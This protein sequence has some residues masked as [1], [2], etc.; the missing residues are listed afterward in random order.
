MTTTP[1]HPLGFLSR[2]S[3]SIYV[4]KPDSAVAPKAAGTHPRLILLATW[5][6]A[7]DVHIAKY[8]SPY[9]AAYPSSPI[10]VVRTELSDFMIPGR[11]AARSREFAGV[12]PIL[13]E[14]FPQLG[15]GGVVPAPQDDTDASSI[16]S[17]S[18]SDIADSDVSGVLVKSS[19]PRPE[20]LIHVWSNGGSTAL[21]HIRA[22]LKKAGVQLPRYSFVM[23]STPGQFHYRSTFTAF[24]LSF[25]PWLRRLLSPFLH[26][27]VCWFWLRQN[28][29]RIFGGAGGPLRTSA[30]SHNTPAAR[31][32]EVRRAYIYSNG[33]KLIHAADVEEHAREAEALGFT[34]RRENFGNSAHVAHMKADPERYWRVARETFEGTP[35]DE[36]EGYTVVE[37]EAEAEAEVVEA[38]AAAR[39]LDRAAE[40]TVSAEKA[41]AA[42]QARADAAAAAAVQEEEAAQG[43]KAALEEAEAAAALAQADEVV[44]AAEVEIEA[45]RAS[46][47]L[48]AAKAS[49]DA[50]AAAAAIALEKA[51]EETASAEEA[52]ARAKADA[53]AAAAAAKPKRGKK[54]GGKH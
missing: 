17:I 26:A 9:R 8:L 36:D 44:A 4:F 30:A 48:E 23:D 22:V 35:V 25:P 47:D 11:R 45:S 10:V 1:P 13:R 12:I 49:D 15:S 21:A 14:A 20:L 5:M 53:E 41:Y 29:S 51:S 24:A 42:A 6:G 43:E 37:A 16:S 3:K 40:E 27:M 50:A 18:T 19:A 54:R 31:A 34:V 38:E 52:Y 7:Q 33:D 28:V 32:A 46:L 2:L 39:A